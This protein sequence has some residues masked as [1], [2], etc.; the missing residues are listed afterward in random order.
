VALAAGA[1]TLI[2]RMAL[3][4]GRAASELRVPGR[5]GVPGVDSSGDTTGLSADGGTLVLADLPRIV[6]SR[7]THLLALDA[8]RL[9]V[10]AKLVLFGYWTV[11]A[12]SPD[13]RWLYLIH[14]PSS[15]ISRYEVRAYD[16]RARRLLP[17]PI[18]DP[19][20]RGEA[21]TGFAVARV[22]SAGERWDYTLYFRPSGTAFIHA[23]NTVGRRAV[24]LDL[25]S[26]AKLDV[27]NAQLRLASSG[28]VLQMVSDGATQALIDTRRLTVIAGAAHRATTPSR[29]MPHPRQVTS[30]LGD[31]PPWE[32]IVVAITALA[33]LA[34]AAAGRRRTRA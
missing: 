5:Y 17:Q 16:L 3:G 4:S 23:L 14:Y 15:D 27:G 30:G 32:F 26:R 1:D 28:A 9:A 33:A 22:M 34:W 21:M 13:G 10:R 18:V 24:C 25:P 12:I 31:G 7:T 11:D 2:K 8:P 6:P 20:D 29:P 19:S